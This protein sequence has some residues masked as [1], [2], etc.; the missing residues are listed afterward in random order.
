MFQYRSTRLGALLWILAVQFFIAQVVAASAWKAPFNLSVRNISDLGNTACAADPS[1]IC[2]PWHAVMNASFVLIGVTMAA[3]AFA[4]RAAF[5][6]GWRRGAA[7]G[8]FTIAGVGVILV[9][10]YPENEDSTRHVLGAAVNFLTGNL[11]LMLFGL[12]LPEPGR[13]GLTWFSVVVGA[14]GLA[15]SVLF[16]RGVDFGIGRGA[17]ERVAAYP[18]AIWQITA[19]IVLMR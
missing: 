17:M 15:A 10:F 7:I 8:L 3:G 9:G 14:I 4:A 1:G 13:R 11:A 2:S 18:M 5:L 16:G 19:G 12:A 6:P